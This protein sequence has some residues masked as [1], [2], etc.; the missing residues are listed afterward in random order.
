[1]EDIDDPNAVPP[2][3]Q[4]PLPAAPPPTEPM[5][6]PSASTEPEGPEVVSFIRPPEQPPSAP[7]P[8]D[9]VS[10][11]ADT[12]TLDVIGDIPPPPIPAPAIP[13]RPTGVAGAPGA[14]TFSLP[15]TAGARPFRTPAFASASRG[16]GFGPGVAVTGAAPTV[17]VGDPDEEGYGGLSADDMGEL[18]RRLA[19]GA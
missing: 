13:R 7:P 15:G 19:G 17:A 11:D 1:M 4:P 2:P 8:P 10:Q 9:A 12:L 5:P 3:P 16:P 14:P 18:L 6:E